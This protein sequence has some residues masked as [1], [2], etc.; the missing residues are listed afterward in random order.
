MMTRLEEHSDKNAEG[1]AQRPRGLS[2]HSSAGARLV[3]G[4]LPSGA[5]CCKS[6]PLL[7]FGAS[8]SLKP[9]AFQASRWGMRKQF[10]GPCLEIHW[11]CS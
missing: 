3:K 4:P 2:G 11:R 5:P 6:C 7:S 8:L 9:S 1:E 10:T